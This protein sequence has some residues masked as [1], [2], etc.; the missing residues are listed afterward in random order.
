MGLFTYFRKRR[1]KRKYRTFVRDVVEMY[2]RDGSV[3]TI[4]GVRIHAK[5]IPRRSDEELRRI[6]FHNANMK[7]AIR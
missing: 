4:N 6:V 2:E 1:E 3:A 7:V 5:D